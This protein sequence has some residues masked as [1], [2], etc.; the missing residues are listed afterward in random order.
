MIKDWFESD[1]FQFYYND[2]NESEAESFV[3][4]IDSFLKIKKGESALDA[5]CGSGRLSV[6]LE[7]KGLDVVGVDYSHTQIEKA[8][9]S[10]THNLKFVLSNIEDYASVQRFDYIF[11]L[12]SSFGY[13]N[14]ETNIRILKN[15]SYH[16]K[17][18]GRLILDYWNC[19]NNKFQK[20][21]LENTIVSKTRN[22]GSMEVKS[23]AYFKDGFYHKDIFLNDSAGSRTFHEKLM[24]LSLPD[25][26][27]YFSESGFKIMEV[28]GDYDLKR[29]NELYSE[30]Q[31]FILKKD[32]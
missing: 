28:F 19:S 4:S 6:V 31:L 5:C 30:R 17:P 14:A 11:N 18:S 10:E 16:L 24:P 23:Q 9:K 22:I 13:T 1:Y 7:K 15:F 25:F 26:V 2:K 12:F 20:M 3:D 32:N 27:K 21:M 8:R 29:Y